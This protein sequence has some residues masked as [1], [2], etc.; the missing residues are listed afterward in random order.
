MTNSA[1]QVETIV[2]A[3]GLGY[4]QV[5]WDT[6]RI[7]NFILAIYDIGF[8]RGHSVGYSFAKEI[9]RETT[10]TENPEDD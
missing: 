6:S 5:D 2:E 1:E 7:D 3:V 8:D 10:S 4:P 9:I